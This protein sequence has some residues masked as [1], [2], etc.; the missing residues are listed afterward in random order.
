MN[1]FSTDVGRF[2]IFIGSSDELVADASMS[3]FIAAIDGSCLILLLLVNAPAENGS[4][5][6]TY[7]FKAG[8]CFEVWWWVTMTE[9]YLPLV[10]VD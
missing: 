6:A 8:S 7:F 3:G 1:T 10:S 5:K 2:I 4:L 9:V